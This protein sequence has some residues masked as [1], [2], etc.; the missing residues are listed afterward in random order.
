MMKVEKNPFLK[1]FKIIHKEVTEVDRFKF[2]DG[3][4]Y[5]LEET[6]I[7]EIDDS[8]SVY[9]VGDMT[10]MM[11]HD[12][13][14]NAGRSVFLYIIYNLPEDQDIIRIPAVLS[15]TGLSESTVRKG[16]K[17]L[18]FA[19]IISRNM[20]GYYWVN[21]RFIFNGNRVGFLNK[22]YPGSIEI[23]KEEE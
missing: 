15:E 20:G 19:G 17:E 8:A 10:R 3:R 16:I 18:V 23:V 1:D 11:F 21:P 7:V 13:I 22:I 12:V 2:P 5:E 4:V 9:Q 6:E 14:T